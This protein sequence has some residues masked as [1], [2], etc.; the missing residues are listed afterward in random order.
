MKLGG[1]NKKIPDERDFKLGALVSLPKLEELPP[2]FKIEPLSI[3]DQIRDGNSDFCASCAT[4][5]MIEPKEE[6]ILYYPFL[7]A[8]SKYES[9]D[10]INSFGLTLRAVCKGLQKHGVPELK[11]IPQEVLNLTPEQRR[12]FNNYPWELKQ[13]ALKHRANSYF[14]VKG[15]YDAF[16]DVRAS[17]WYFKDKKQLVLFGLEFGWPLYESVL[18]L[19]DNNGGFGH[20]MYICGWEGDYLL[21]VNSAGV[22][23]GDGGIHKIPRETFN[24]YAD[25]YGVMMVVDIPRGDSEYML[26]NQIKLEDNWLVLFLKVLKALFR[27]A[28]GWR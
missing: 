26:Q 12:D 2:A 22:N 6:V 15:P 27:E 16:D 3:K 25:E 24:H 8:A 20:A 23:A 13:T 7:F 1:L 11:D 17:I 19:K 28:L 9:G 4:S 14:E 10:D 21:A 5:G 18:N